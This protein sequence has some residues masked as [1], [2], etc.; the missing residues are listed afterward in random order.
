MKP[1]RAGLDAG[2]IE[3]LKV[4]DAKKASACQ[5][6][7]AE[8]NSKHELVG[9][10][11]LFKGAANASQQLSADVRTGTADP[12]FVAPIKFGEKERETTTTASESWSAP[13]YSTSVN[14]RDWHNSP[15]LQRDRARRH[16][17][18]Q[19]RRKLFSSHRGLAHT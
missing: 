6:D 16:D 17:F 18:C 9:G 5:R 14:L 10:T 7:L 19:P 12:I 1:K 13:A 15:A 3:E 2:M 4:S 8:H 11:P